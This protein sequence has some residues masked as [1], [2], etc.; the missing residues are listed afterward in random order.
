MSRPLTPLALT[1]LRMLSDGP[2]HPYEM[3]QRIRD[4]GYDQAV[5]V[6]HGSLYHAVERLTATGLIEPMKT[7]REGRRPERTV[8]AITEAGQ[9]AAHARMRE[10]ITELDREY[11]LF[12]TALAFINLLPEPEVARLLRSREV[13]LEAKVAAHG[14]VFDALRKQ[15]LERYKLIDLEYCQTLERTQL[16]FVRALADDVETG[17]LTWD[18]MEDK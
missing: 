2:M 8:Y 6:T 3:Q 1:L 9:D 5:K 7:S 4:H 12:G 15:G 13:G 11:P 14:A 16:D 10:I 18:D 17:R